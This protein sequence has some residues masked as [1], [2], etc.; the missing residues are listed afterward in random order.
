MNMKRTDFMSRAS[1][2]D[3]DGAVRPLDPD[4][5]LWVSAHEFYQKY[6]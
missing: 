4:L 2:G 3:R 5:P 6:F 1:K